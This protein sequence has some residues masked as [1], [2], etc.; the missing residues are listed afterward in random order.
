MQHTLL[1]DYLKSE[2]KY[3]KTI[4]KWLE[5]EKKYFN[6]LLSI[7]EKENQPNGALKNDKLDIDFESLKKMENT[8]SK[9]IPSDTAINHFKILTER[10]SKNGNPFLSKE[11]LFIFIEKGFLDVQTH[12]KQQINLSN[13]EKGFVIKRF[14]EFFDLA[15]SQYNE[16]NKKFRY[17]KLLSDCFDNW[18]AKASSLSLDLTKQ[19]KVGNSFARFACFFAR[20]ARKLISLKHKHTIALLNIEQWKKLHLKHSRKL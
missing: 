15:V 10:K 14:Y 6:E 7:L 12:P 19:R 17:I 9:G 1:K 2:K 20:F 8:F 5:N 13:G 4:K 18:D 16:L 11:Q 3:I